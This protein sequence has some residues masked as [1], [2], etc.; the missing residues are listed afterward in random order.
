MQMKKAAKK[1]A[2][3]KKFITNKQLNFG[4]KTADN[5]E[6]RFFV[7]SDG[8]IKT[9]SGVS[10]ESQ[11]AMVWADGNTAFKIMSSGNEEA[12]VA[13][14]TE[15]TLQVEGDYKEFM[16]FSRSLDIMMGKP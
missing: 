6:G 13:A 4:I 10:A 15:K 16:W 8:K 5:K 1:D 2:R 12:S 3:F 7:F 14:L 9:K 11:S